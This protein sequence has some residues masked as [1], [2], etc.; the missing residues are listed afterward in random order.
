MESRSIGC[1]VTAGAHPGGR[2]CV[3]GGGSGPP[4]GP[5]RFHFFSSFCMRTLLVS[6]LG[7]GL[8]TAAG[9]Q[10]APVKTT[11]TATATS[12]STRTT[13]TR[14][15]V[16]AVV[17]K[18]KATTKTHKATAHKATAH[19]RRTTKRRTATTVST[20]PMP[21][22]NSRTA[23]RDTAL[24][25]SDAKAQAQGGYAAPGMPTNINSGGNTGGYNSAKP[26]AKPG[27]TLGSGK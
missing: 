1:K 4:I 9:A 25:S 15:P 27:T 12:S 5:L 17:V 7:L 3:R 8:A 19:K 6:L 24:Q 18:N 22:D 13:T 10:T 21:A 11:K 20:A 2:P 26:T 14:P 16:Q 23:P